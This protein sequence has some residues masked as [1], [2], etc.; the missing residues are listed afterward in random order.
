MK[1]VF[2]YTIH[3][4]LNTVRMSYDAK[5]LSVQLQH[6]EPQVWAL[7][8][9]RGRTSERIFKTVMTGEPFEDQG[10]LY[11]GTVQIG[12]IVVHVFEVL[13]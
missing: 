4:G 7:V 12:P 13:P 10:C 1:Q 3:P 9:P 5:I 6:G 8:D 11:I 2:K